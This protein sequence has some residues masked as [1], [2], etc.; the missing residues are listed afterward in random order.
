MD[1]S[2]MKK[3]GAKLSIASKKYADPTW[4]MMT[5]ILHKDL[6]AHRTCIPG[7]D[8]GKIIEDD[9]LCKRSTCMALK[10]TLEMDSER[11]PDEGISII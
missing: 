9:R 8:F 5:A 2:K 3:P 1:L 4:N 11:T 10:N 6:P 7:D